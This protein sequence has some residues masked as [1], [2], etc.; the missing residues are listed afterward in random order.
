MNVIFN[1]ENLKKTILCV[2]Y[3][4]FG[5][6]FCII[7]NKMLG[8]VESALC[9]ILIIVGVFCV[10]VYSLM[11]S[12]DKDM[13][14]LIFGILTLLLGFL[15]LIISK[16][17]AIFL[18]IL[19]GLNG[20]ILIIDALKLRKLQKEWISDFIVGIVVCVFSLIVIVL[21]STSFSRNILAVFLGVILLINGIYS[22]IELGIIM[23]KAKESTKG[24]ET[25]EIEGKIIEQESGEKISK[26]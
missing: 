14:L 1:K 2:I 9:L 8:F 19:I 18:S 21:S 22:A 6:L 11:P 13:K 10:L 15:S 23:S 24:N 3:L 7:P 17:F 25:I 4:V 26:E 16:F 5:L 12:D 20:V